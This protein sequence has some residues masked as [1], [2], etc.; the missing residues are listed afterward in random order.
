LISSKPKKK[1]CVMKE[2]D[3]GV[4]K[5]AKNRKAIY[6]THMKGNICAVKLEI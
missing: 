3:V 2:E 1:R 5:T 4:S 6:W